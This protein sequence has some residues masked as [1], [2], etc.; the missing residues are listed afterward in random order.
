[1]LC[2]PRYDERNARYAD[3]MER[4]NEGNMTNSLVEKEVRNCET[5]RFARDAAKVCRAGGCASR[6]M[7]EGDC[8]MYAMSAEAFLRRAMNTQRRIA[9]LEALAARYREMATGSTA[10]LRTIKVRGSLGG[11]LAAGMDSYMDVC[12][13]IE[14]EAQKLRDHF[15]ETMHVLSR[16]PEPQEREVLEL[17]YLTGLSMTAAARHMD[18]CERTAHRLREQGLARVQREMDLMEYAAHRPGW[19]PSGVRAQAVP[20][21]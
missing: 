21:S 7:P 1:M 18:C 15:R 8:P 11:R 12:T 6:C 9:N 20:P 4:E 13:Q 10:P 3:M 14:Q 5:C 17:H 16:L 19:N 2:V